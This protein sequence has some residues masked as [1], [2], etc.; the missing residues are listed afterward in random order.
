MG[1]TKRIDN[2]TCLDTTKINKRMGPP[3]SA[4]IELTSKCNLNCS[5][6][7]TS[8]YLRTKGYMDFSLFKKISRDLKKSGVKE[9]GVFYL[10]ESLLYPKLAEAIFFLKKDL[11]FKWV[12]LT[13]N[14]VLANPLLLKEI[15]KS[16]LDSLK[17]SFNSYSPENYKKITGTSGSNYDTV[18]KNIKT[19]Y[20]IR[21]KNGFSCG[22]YASS[23][24]YSD[25]FYKKMS[26]SLEKI[27]PYIDEHYWLPLYSHA[28]YSS[29]HTEHVGNTGRLSNPQSPIPCWTLFNEAHIT[30]D[31]KLS[32][33]CFD[34]EGKFIM[35][36]LKLNS[37]LEC[38]NSPRFQKLRK[39]HID[40]KI[41]NTVCADCL[42][43]K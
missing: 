37:F 41:K 39:D 12:F 20:N 31:G 21:E 17:F 32:A 13:T 19:A 43:G 24:Y 30:Y 28:G 29:D 22:I 14:G 1:I 9:I 7:G 26:K 15:M 16:G 3:I 36:D 5:F 40:K 18:I 2:V 27:K 10:G 11:G 33:C 35:G 25:T 4:K 38:W 8:G 34:Q 6:C 42:V 23:I